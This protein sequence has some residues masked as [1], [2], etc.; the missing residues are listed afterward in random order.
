[1]LAAFLALPWIVGPG[2]DA[3]PSVSITKREKVLLQIRPMSSSGPLDS[4]P[5]APHRL[6][7]D[8]NRGNVVEF[9]VRWPYD[10][11]TAHLQLSAQERPPTAGQDHAVALEAVL[12]LADGRRA[13]STRSHAFSDTS[14]FLFEVYREGELPLTLVVEAST[15]L[16]TTVST[17]PEVGDPIL[18]LL[19]IQ[20]VESGRSISLE[21]DRLSTFVGQPVSYSFRMGD[22]ADAESVL[23]QFKP[24]RLLGEIAE[25][26]VELSGKLPSPDGLQVIS[27]TEQWIAS[28]GAQSTLSFESG[29]PPTG[30]RFLVTAQ[31]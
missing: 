28:R 30:Y 18:L 24:L 27:R 10:T 7:V 12:K 19:E 31:F 4:S 20:R 9:D 26:Q 21:T 15:V 13:K 22:Q 8:P 16:E 1:M 11:S 29:E 2:S 17:E 14:T 6:E 25:I 3:A 5:A 23:V